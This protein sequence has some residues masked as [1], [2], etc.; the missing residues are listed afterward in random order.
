MLEDSPLGVRDESLHLIDIDLADDLVV[1]LA[2]HVELHDVPGDGLRT[3]PDFYQQN[4]T[5]G[6]GYTYPVSRLVVF[7][8]DE[9]DQVET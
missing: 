4:T 3:R 7:V 8:F 5:S 2:I 9:E 1:R 6:L